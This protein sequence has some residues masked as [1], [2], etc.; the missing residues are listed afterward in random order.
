VTA[1]QVAQELKVNSRRVYRW[2]QDGELVA[3][4]LGT[5]SRHNYRLQ[6][7]DLE[8]FKRRRRTGQRWL[9]PFLPYFSSVLT[10]FALC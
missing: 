3:T 5:P 6:R 2:I 9:T 4:D 8:D 1:E 10:R 7:T